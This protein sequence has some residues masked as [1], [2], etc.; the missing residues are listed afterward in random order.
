MLHLTGKSWVKRGSFSLPSQVSV[1]QEM[2]VASSMTKLW[3]VV[4]L[5]AV[6]FT[7][8]RVNLRV[9]FLSVNAP[10]RDFRQDRIIDKRKDKEKNSLVI[11]A[12]GWDLGH[13]Y[14]FCHSFL[15]DLR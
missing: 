14:L 10:L 15:W 9:G 11:K 12:L 5:L 4:A 8:D 13:R 2:P 1:V 7:L 6:A 3:M